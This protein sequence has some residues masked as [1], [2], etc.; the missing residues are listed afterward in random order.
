M[1]SYGFDRFELDVDRLL[2]THD[3]QNVGLG[4]KVVE[5][6]LALVEQPGEILAK[7]V[8]LDRIWP[9][10]FVEEANLAQNVHVLRR[11]FRQYR[12]A[13]PIETIP[14][15]GYRF[16]AEARLL[17]EPSERTAGSPLRRPRARRMAALLTG[18]AVVAAA[19]VL[20]AGN[21]I[22]HRSDRAHRLSANG[23]ALYQIGWYY[24]NLRTR[25]S[26][27]KSLVYFARVI[28][29]DPADARGYAALANANVAMGEYCYGTHQPSVYFA[30]AEE[31]ARKGLAL[32]PQSAEA[33]AALGILALEDRKTTVAVGELRHA[34]ALDPSYAPAEEWYGMALLRDGRIPQAVVHLRTAARLDPLSVATTASLGVAAYRQQRFGEA[35]VYS[36]QALELSPKRVDALA[37][38][39]R[40][41]EAVGDVD[42]AIAAF[43]RYGG[44]DP[45]YRAEAAAL[46]AH[47]YALGRRLPE[48]REQLTYARAHEGDVDP[49]DLAA[50]AQAVGTRAGPPAA[51]HSLRLTLYA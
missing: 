44:V 28:D 15:R 43:K 6:L 29:A 34:I 33:H 46:L 30:R 2:L 42:R 21:G 47:A 27:R 45:F 22:A 39:G 8:L 35:I 36:R 14:R 20:A 38:I 50:A 12:V 25:E 10:G 31:Y 37:T 5:T 1:L 18:A 48:A 32:N 23:A 40:A 4:P 41:Y 7:N 51:G 9:D 19:F 49:T 24:W 13:D 17:P 11:M 16:T 3:G 26:V